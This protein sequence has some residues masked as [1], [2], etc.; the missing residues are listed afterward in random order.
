MNTKGDVPIWVLLAA[1]IVVL[2]FFVLKGL[3]I[4]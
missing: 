2:L 3:N 1:L 4:I